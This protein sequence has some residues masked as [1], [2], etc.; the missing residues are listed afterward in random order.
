MAFLRQFQKKIQSCE[1]RGKIIQYIEVDEQDLRLA[2]PL[3]VRALG[4]C[5]DELAPP[6]R[7]F[8]I[9]LHN[10]VA[11]LAKEREVKLSSVRI[12]QRDIRAATNWSDTQVRRYL[13]RLL[14]MEY[15]IQ[16]RIP[17]TGARYE[18]ELFYDGQGKDG[19]SFLPFT[20]IV[21]SSSLN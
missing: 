18:Y 11:N 21:C 14:K 6:V 1:H 20:E 13:D 3:A 7:S 4:R 8:L 19:E 17:G 15:I 5:L 9:T 16:H 12:T 10:H 2:H